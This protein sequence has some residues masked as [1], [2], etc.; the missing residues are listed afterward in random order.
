M[1]LT[2]AQQILN[3]PNQINLIQALECN[4][5]SIDRLAEIRQEIAQVLGADVQVIELATQAIARA[6]ARE[7]VRKEGEASVARMQ[8][9]ATVQV[10][11]LTV[12]GALLIGMLALANVRERRGEI[13][14]LRALG[15]PTGSILRLFL[16][17]ALL[18]GLL[19][20]IL[21]IAL[22]CLLTGQFEREAAEGG[23][24]LS[25]WELFSP[26]IAL[27]LVVLTP[28]LTILASWVPAVL[29]A[30]QDPANVLASD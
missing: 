29:A 6:E 3:L 19:G 27:T 5:S 1:D 9:R 15:T 7:T 21:G 30:G 23:P 13:G 10:F 8:Q 22:G 18:V 17:K 26:Q 12:A 24:A 11:L 28:A 4:C 25:V 14:I 20:A 2:L 16:T